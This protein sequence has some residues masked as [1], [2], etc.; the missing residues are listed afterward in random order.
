M[1]TSSASCWMLAEP[2]GAG[3]VC[4]ECGSGPSAIRDGRLCAP[5]LPILYAEVYRGLPEKGESTSPLPA[6]DKEKLMAPSPTSQ[7]TAPLKGRSEPQGG[8]IVTAASSARGE[9][10][11]RPAIWRDAQAIHG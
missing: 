10:W 5:A 3:G 6:T 9:S 8:S 4:D 1:K 7:L 2:S 11:T